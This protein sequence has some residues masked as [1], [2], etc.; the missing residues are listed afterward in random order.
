M[1]ASVGGDTRKRSNTSGSSEETYEDRIVLLTGEDLSNINTE[2]EVSDDNQDDS[3]SLKLIK[4][5]HSFLEAGG[6]SRREKFTLQSKRLRTRYCTQRFAIYSHAL[7]A[8]NCSDIT[9]IDCPFGALF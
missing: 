8:I 3:G 2:S 1:A 9:P 7:N 4:S 6:N 5:N